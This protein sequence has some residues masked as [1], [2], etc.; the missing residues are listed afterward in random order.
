MIL[1]VLLLKGEVTATV[2]LRIKFYI[3]I[4]DNSTKEGKEELCISDICF[5][6]KGSLENKK[7]I[8]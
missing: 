6:R 5:R 2:K 3:F 7:S 4:R 8:S 1:L